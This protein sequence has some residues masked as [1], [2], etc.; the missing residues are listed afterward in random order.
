MSEYRRLQW[1]VRRGRCCLT[2]EFFNA[3]WN[4]GIKV[5]PCPAQGGLVPRSMGVFLAPV[6]SYAAARPAAVRRVDDH[7][8]RCGLIA[9]SSKEE[10]MK[11]VLSRRESWRDM[12]LDEVSIRSS[13]DEV[14]VASAYGMM[15]RRTSSSKTV[16]G[17]SVSLSR[18]DM[19][20]WQLCFPLL[21]LTLMGG[22][23]RN[24]IAK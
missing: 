24:M 15:A 13:V 9:V 20:S 4:S 21:P 10:T 2:S 1:G 3:H 16:P 7:L 14:E 8:E 17:A 12:I 19:E 22:G 18:T 11:L 6:S 23:E 5:F